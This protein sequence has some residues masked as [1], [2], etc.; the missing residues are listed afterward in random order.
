ML[1]K[2]GYFDIKIEIYLYLNPLFDH[3]GRGVHTRPVNKI[4][5]LN[6]TKQGRGVLNLPI[7]ILRYLGWEKND[8]ILVRMMP[9]GSIGLYNIDRVSNVEEIDLQKF[10][11]NPILV[12]EKRK[13]KKP[14]LVNQF[15]D[16]DDYEEWLSERKHP[17]KYFTVPELKETMLKRP[18]AAKP[19]AK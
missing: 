18:K 16:F 19:K 14:K 2:I 8:Q 6:I 12:Y 17:K 10:S 1:T 11:I 3:M 9:D 5:P 7:A 13:I 15:A 4:K